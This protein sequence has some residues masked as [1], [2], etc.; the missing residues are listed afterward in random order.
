MLFFFFFY[1]TNFQNQQKSIKVVFS[2]ETPNE[3]S[4]VFLFKLLVAA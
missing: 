4:T 1:S 3:E 2:L